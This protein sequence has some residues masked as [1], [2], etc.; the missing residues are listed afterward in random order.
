[1]LLAVDPGVLAL[2]Y[3][4]FNIDLQLDDL[5]HAGA[6]LGY[7]VPAFRGGG[8]SMASKRTLQFGGFGAL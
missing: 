1:M 7:V 3:W 2:P 8:V 5:R 4:D 6:P